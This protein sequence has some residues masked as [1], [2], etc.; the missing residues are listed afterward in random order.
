M[1]KSKVLFFSFLLFFFENIA[2]QNVR[3]YFQ[4]ECNYVI[5]AQLDDKKNVLICEMNLEYINHSPDKLSEIYFNLWANAYSDT[6]TAFALQQR[7]DG[8]KKFLQSVEETRGGYNYLEFFIEDNKVEAKKYNGHKDIAQ[9]SLEKPLEAGAKLDIK[10]KFLLKIPESFSRLGRTDEAYQMTQWYPKPAVYDRYGWHPMPY[11]DWGEFYSEFGNFDVTISLPAEYVVAATG[12]LQ[13]ESEIKWL[14]EL[15][16]Y[17]KNYFSD[18]AKNTDYPKRKEKKKTIR[19]VQKNVH[20]FAFFADKKFFVRQSD[21]TL[22]SGK[23]VKAFSY[24][25][26]DRTSS[27]M[28]QKAHEYLRDAVLF[29]SEKVGEYPYSVVS[30]VENKSSEGGGMEYPTVTLIGEETSDFDLDLV[31][32]HEVGHNWFYGILGSNERQHAWMDEGL[33]SFLETR[34]VL[35]KYPAVAMSPYYAFGAKELGFQSRRYENTHFVRSILTDRAGRNLGMNT[36]LDA[37]P[38]SYYYYTLHYEKPAALFFYLKEYLSEAVT[39]KAMQTYF[40]KW[41]FKHPY[42]ADLKAVFEEVS[43]KNLSWFFDGLITENKQFDIILTSCK[44]SENEIVLQIECTGGAE[45]P[46]PVS[47]LDENKKILKTI[48]VEAFAGTK[49]ITEKIDGVKSAVIDF[50]DITLDRDKLDNGCK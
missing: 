13:T 35:K 27:R 47:F 6:N 20:D 22:P 28:W 12:E 1:F 19:Y 23:I 45:V 31:I 16:E 32:T 2:A 17:T 4:Q 48:W 40:E 14:A 43:G 44:A 37:L 34:Y 41:K 30:A 21:I 39:D 15:D 10:I 46:F 24:F 29:Y 9:I 3:E 42:P 8:K 26:R 50:Y 5:K 18:D 36:P 38:V 33:N 49:E 7:K 25:E 11:L